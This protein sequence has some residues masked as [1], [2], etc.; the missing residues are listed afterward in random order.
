MPVNRRR[1]A[2]LVDTASRA[3]TERTT[4]GR[5]LVAMR[6]ELRSRRVPLHWTHVF[7]VVTMAGL[8]VLFV[9]GVILMFAYDPSSEL[10]RYDGPY[11]PLHGAEASGAFISVMRLSFEVPGGLLLRQLHHWAGLLV[12]VS[13]MLQLLVSF[14]TGAFRRPRRANW[15]LLFLLFIVTLAGGWSGYALPDDML[16]GSGL[17]IVEGIV[18]GIPVIG[19]WLASLLFGGA[20]PGAIIENLYGIHVLIVPAALLLIVVVRAWRAYRIQPPQFAGTS[21]REDNIVGVPLATAA[22]RA[23]GVFAVVTAALFVVASAV[24]VGPI[25]VYGPSDPGNAGAGSQPDWYTG[26]LDGALRL[27]P[28]GWEFE[29]M[30]RTVTLAVLVP[31]AVVGVFLLVVAAYPFLEEWITGDRGEHHILDRP[32]NVASRTGVGVAGIVF[33]AALW[34]AASADLIAVAFH[35]GLEAVI[36][37]FQVTLIVGPVIGFAVARRIALA[38]QKKDLELVVH[39]YETGRIVRLPGGRYVELH[40]GLDEDERA[41][42][43]HRAVR[44]IAPRPDEAGRLTRLERVRGAL[45]ERFFAD[46]VEVPE[47]AAEAAGAIAGA[48]HDDAEPAGGRPLSRVDGAA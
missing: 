7:G 17:R 35:V 32:R 46:R 31:L 41:R 16:S 23:G 20:F 5:R 9:T 38:L 8:A 1:R 43:A 48:P 6:A 30:G 21:R 29:W 45:A 26:F 42:L 37:T 14:F 22:T 39:G 3:L 15:V 13:I 18:L 2:S 10:A 4:L 28:P 11:V 12:P 36:T 33:Y 34:G 24:T 47:R 44:P 25:W 27:V 40:A 19:T